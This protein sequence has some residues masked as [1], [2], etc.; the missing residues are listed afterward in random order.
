MEPLRLFDE[1]FLHRGA[2]KMAEMDYVTK[3]F[4]WA[5][6]AMKEAL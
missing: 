5:L 4:P 2:I 3:E 6:L 1:I